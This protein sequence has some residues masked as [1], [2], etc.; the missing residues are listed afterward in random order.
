VLAQGT[1]EEVERAREILGAT[2]ATQFA[3]PSP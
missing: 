2:V 1:H 3:V